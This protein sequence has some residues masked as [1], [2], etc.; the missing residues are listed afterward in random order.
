[1]FH[2]LLHLLFHL[3]FN[4]RFHRL[5]NHALQYLR[6][7]LHRVGPVLANNSGRIHVLWPKQKES[8][9]VGAESE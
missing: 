2:L 8:F 4:L 9:F 5:L 6:L 1:M 7:M 3:L